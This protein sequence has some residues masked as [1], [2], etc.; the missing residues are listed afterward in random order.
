MKFVQ[1]TPAGQDAAWD[2]PD[3]AGGSQGEG[4][5]GSTISL[6]PVMDNTRRRSPGIRAQS[7]IDILQLIH[8]NGPG[9]A[10]TAPVNERGERSN[11]AIGPESPFPSTGSSTTGMGP[12]SPWISI[13]GQDPASPALSVR[14]AVL[15]RA[16]IHKIAPWVCIINLVRAFHADRSG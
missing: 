7:G 5:N 16:F 14:E 2:E 10:S 3:A 1:D 8:G 12:N 15:F 4:Q 13:D 6:S 11:G 9:I